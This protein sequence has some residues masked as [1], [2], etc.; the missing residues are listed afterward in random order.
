MDCFKTHKKK[1]QKSQRKKRK[2]VLITRKTII[3]PSPKRKTSKKKCKLIRK[4]LC[5]RKKIY[6]P[7]LVPPGIQGP[8]GPPGERGITGLQGPRGPQGEQGISGLQGPPGQQGPQGEQGLPG[9]LPEVNIIPTVS[10]FFYFPISDLVLFAPVT[11]PANLFTDDDGISIISF[12]IL[13]INSCNC[14]FINGILQEGSIY[15]L[16]PIALTFS[17]Q[18]NII[19]AGSPIILY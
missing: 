15:S 5:V 19:Y 13:G 17:P 9:P 14:L 18:D 8:P 4:K 2:K 7:I 12:P 3:C 1:Q 10:R 16:N 6:V 11:I